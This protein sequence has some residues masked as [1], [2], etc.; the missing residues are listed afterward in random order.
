MVIDHGVAYAAAIGSGSIELVVSY[1]PGGAP[2]M[3]RYYLSGPS[4][5]PDQHLRFELPL[6]SLINTV[7]PPFQ[8]GQINLIQFAARDYRPPIAETK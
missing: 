8:C 3:C 2:S 7:G 1:D 4:S 5:D 6:R